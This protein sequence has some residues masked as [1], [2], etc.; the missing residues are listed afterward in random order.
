MSSVSVRLRIAGVAALAAVA[1]GVL[2]YYAVHDPSEGDAP[3][4][5]FKA[6]TGYDCPGCGAQRALHTA[7]NGDFA[8]AWRFN[9]FIFVAVPVAVIYMI[10]ETAPGRMPRL[11]RVLLSP[12]FMILVAVAI[13]GWW[14]IRNL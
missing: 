10:V 2:V 11:R 1:A 8:A 3:R 6:F 13:A 14:I 7:L 12:P 5:L 9:P 4:C